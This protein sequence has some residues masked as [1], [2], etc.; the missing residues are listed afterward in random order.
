MTNV[1]RELASGKPIYVGID[2][3]KK[4]FAIAVVCCGEEI[5][6]MQM[7]ANGD[8]LVAFLRSLHASEVHTVLEAG[9]TGFWVHDILTAAGFDSMVVAPTLV[10]SVSTRV[11]TDRRD[12]L[13][14]AVLLAGG[15]LRGI[16]VPTPRKR[17]DRQLV[18]S[19]EQVV[20]ARGQVMRQ[21]K[22]V[23]LFHGVRSP[24]GMREAWSGKYVRWLR[25]FE[26][27]YVSLS[28]TIVELLGRYDSLGEQLERAKKS[29]E[30]LSKSDEYAL[31]AEIL[32]SIPGIGML[33]AIRLV[34]ELPDVRKFRNGSSF[35]SYNG[36][37]P[38]EHSS[39]EQKR[40]GRIT[41]CG[42]RHVRT[43]LIESSWTLIRHDAEERRVFYAICHG[44]ARRANIAIVAIAR[45]LAVRIRRMLIDGT[46]YDPSIPAAKRPP[47]KK[48]RTTLRLQKA[49]TPEKAPMPEG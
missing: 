45:R 46:K 7:E 10:P 24:S 34:V 41:K 3:H 48:N 6:R 44:D 31:A 40:R 28:T 12:C 26:W 5:V 13:K 16:E 33:T 4:T 35:A 15:M 32:D 25:E 27:P 8:M 29:L 2:V 18:R 47:Q 1:R 14:L 43:A 21:I 19:R 39:G 37:A 49:A 22:S 38:S 11:K 42:N 36:L 9:P 30:E 20:R 17:A 23:L